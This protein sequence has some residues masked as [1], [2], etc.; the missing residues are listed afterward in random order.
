MAS[1]IISCDS[2]AN[3]CINAYAPYKSTKAKEEFRIA[4]AFFRLCDTDPICYT[5]EQEMCDAYENGTLQ[6]LDCGRGEFSDPTQNTETDNYGCSDST[7]VVDYSMTLTMYFRF[8]P[9]N[10]EFFEQICDGNYAEFGWVSC[11]NLTYVAPS[12]AEVSVVGPIDDG[13]FKAFKVTA[14]W[15]QKCGIMRS[16]PARAPLAYV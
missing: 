4:R 5:V 6:I 7:F 9:A 16:L 3:G 2:A 10:E 11:C 8:D 14:T 1:V 13:G 12:D 15:N